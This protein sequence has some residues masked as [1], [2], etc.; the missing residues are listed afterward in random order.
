MTPTLILLLVIGILAVA[1]VAWFVAQRQRSQA[2]RGRFGREYDRTVD[3]IG[4]RREAEAELEERERRVEGLAIRP[5][6]AGDRERWAA[7]WRSVQAQ[8]VDDPGGAIR[9]ADGLIQQVMEARGYPVAD[10]DRRVADISV[11]HPDVVEHYRVAHEIASRPTDRTMSDTEALR[12]AMVHY[13]ALFESLLEGDDA[14]GERPDV[15]T[16]R[17][18]ADAARTAR[19]TR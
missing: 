13:R 10:F 11:D 2:L 16:T 12:Q 18:D 19:S 5:L 14:T 1:I 9:E 17:R 4:S 3:E 8:F 15:A 7:D 6:P